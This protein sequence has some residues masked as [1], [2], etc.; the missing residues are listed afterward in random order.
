MVQL[1]GSENRISVARQRY[2]EAVGTYNVQVRQFPGTLM[3]KV[4]G[5]EQ[6]EMFKAVEEAKTAPKVNLDTTK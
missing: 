3:A 1:E 6:K 2:N 5:F 4:F